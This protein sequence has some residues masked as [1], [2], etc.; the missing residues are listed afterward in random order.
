MRENYPIWFSDTISERGTNNLGFAPT[1]SNTDFK[2]IL[3]YYEI[4][5][6]LFLKSDFSSLIHIYALINNTIHFISV[7]LKGWAFVPLK[8]LV[9]SSKLRIKWF[10]CLKEIS[11]LI[12]FDILLIGS[13]RPDQLETVSK[14]RLKTVKTVKFST[15]FKKKN[16]L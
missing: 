15:F 14:A 13:K 3:A 2:F 12:S 11:F 9:C 10:R 7:L 4:R 1:S 6:N 5:W 8:V 16:R